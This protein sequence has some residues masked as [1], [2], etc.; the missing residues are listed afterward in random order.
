MLQV[1]RPE[2]NQAEQLPAGMKAGFELRILSEQDQRS[3]MVELTAENGQTW[4]V[5]I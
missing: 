5:E 1:E 4:F 3:F 2:V